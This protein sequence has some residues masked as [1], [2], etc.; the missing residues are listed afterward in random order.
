MGA[1]AH[2]QLSDDMSGIC[3]LPTF[4]TTTTAGASA[5]DLSE[6][7]AEQ[8]NLLVCITTNALMGYDELTIRPV[9][10]VY[11]LIKEPAGT[12]ILTRQEAAWSTLLDDFKDRA[13]I[14]ASTL[15]TGIKQ[16]KARFFVPPKEEG[17]A[18]RVVEQWTSKEQRELKRALPDTIEIEGSIK[19]ANGEESPL[20]VVVHIPFQEPPA[21]S[22]MVTNTPAP[23][24]QSGG[25]APAPQ[26]RES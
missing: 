1:I 24:E 8:E 3:L 22:T 4:T 26:T 25:P 11:R 15:L 9:K 20:T 17:A 13:K 16:L 18:W 7:A 10:V 6:H 5:D 14:P 21:A 19:I 2:R 23:P 12:F